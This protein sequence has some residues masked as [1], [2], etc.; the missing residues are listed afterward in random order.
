MK[1]FQIIYEIAPKKLIVLNFW[2]SRQNSEK[3]EYLK[4]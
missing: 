3:N 1:N 2:D 4:K